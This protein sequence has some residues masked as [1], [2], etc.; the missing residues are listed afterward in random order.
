MSKYMRKNYASPLTKEDLKKHG[1]CDVDFET[2]TVYGENG[3]IEPRRNK[4]GYLMIYLNDFDENGNPIKIYSKK[5][6]KHYTYRKFSITLSRL[7]WVWKNGYIEA[8]YVVDHVK[9]QHTEL[10]DYDLNN[11]QSITA[12]ANVIKDRNYVNQKMIPCKRPLAY[13][14]NKLAMYLDLYEQAKANGDAEAAH[15]LR[16]NIA[17]NRAKIRYLTQKESGDCEHDLSEDTVH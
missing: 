1:V 5:D 6:P 10:S 7:L 15:R 8:G 12:G 11:L 3:K 14:E 13:Y 17:N 9:N 16:S 2:L 4:Q